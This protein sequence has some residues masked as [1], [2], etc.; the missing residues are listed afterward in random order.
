MDASQDPDYLRTTQNAVREFRSK[1]REF[2]AL[3]VPTTEG[4]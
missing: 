3:H 4:A 1:F 2:L